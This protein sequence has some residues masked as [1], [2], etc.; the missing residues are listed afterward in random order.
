MPSEQPRYKLL[1]VPGCATAYR[2]PEVEHAHGVASR[3][4]NRSVRATS[5]RS[6]DVH[7]TT[8]TEYVQDAKG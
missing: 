8:S 6:G 4:P 3:R 2:V 5:L 1:R 7:E